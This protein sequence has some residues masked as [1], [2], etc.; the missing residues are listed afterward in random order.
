MGVR[1]PI[2]R[3]NEGVVE[4]TEAIKQ[5]STVDSCERHDQVGSHSKKVVT[6]ASE[7]LAILLHLI[8]G[9]MNSSI[10]EG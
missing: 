9:I 7:L 10:I 2:A 3:L 1:S 5:T 4:Q 6:P 8:S